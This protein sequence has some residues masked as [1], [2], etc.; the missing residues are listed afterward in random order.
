MKDKSPDI[1]GAIPAGDERDD[2]AIARIVDTQNVSY[3]EARNIYLGEPQ[4]RPVDDPRETLHLPGKPL[5]F[6]PIG[7]VKDFHDAGRLDKYRGGMGVPEPGSPAAEN[8][9][10]GLAEWRS[11]TDSRKFAELIEQYAEKL[12]T[13]RRDRV[14]SLKGE[15]IAHWRTY[16]LKAHPELSNSE[17]NDAVSDM[18]DALETIN[19]SH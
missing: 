4:S 19:P 11:K 16:L 2:E 12:Q 17:S 3:L 15:F 7:H 13:V 10:K 1:L 9:Y 14:P 5:S 8:M 6:A 18:R